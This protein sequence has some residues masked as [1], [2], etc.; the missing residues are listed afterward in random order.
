[1][2]AAAEYGGIIAATLSAGDFD[3]SMEVYSV[4]YSEL[5]GSIDDVL[6]SKNINNIDLSVLNAELNH[7]IGL[8][9]TYFDKWYDKSEFKQCNYILTRL[10][11]IFSEEVDFAAEYNKVCYLIRQNM[12]VA[13]GT[14]KN[15][16]CAP[17]LFKSTIFDD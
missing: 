7:I 4:A 8:F 5:R 17:E 10:A 2:S 16:F 15:I 11:T 1:M 3:T 12:P 14:E 13:V 9:K 6:Y